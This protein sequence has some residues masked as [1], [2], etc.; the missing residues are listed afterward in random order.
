MSKTITRADL[1]E[2]IYEDVGLSRS[3]SAQFVDDIIEEICLELEAGQDVK[4]SGFG[5]LVVKEKGARIGR[6][7]KTG[8]EVTIQPRKV[9]SFKASHLLK[10]AMNSDL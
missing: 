1:A 3:E 2:A 7:P 5:T 10:D 6:N 9:L 4:M 8:E